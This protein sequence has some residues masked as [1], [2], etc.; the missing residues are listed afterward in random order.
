M[1]IMF[2][3]ETEIHKT[4]LVLKLNLTCKIIKSIGKRWFRFNYN[5]HSLYLWRS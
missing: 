1:I 3:L 5:I 2:D 4:Y